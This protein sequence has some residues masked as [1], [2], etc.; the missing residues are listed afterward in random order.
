ML[1]GPVV[2]VVE[3][4]TI[5]ILDAAQRQ[6]KI[7]LAGIDAPESEQPFGEQSKERLAAMIDGKDVTVLWF[8]MDHLGRLIGKVWLNGQDVNLEM[9]RAGLAWHFT[10]YAAEQPEE[11]RPVYA[12]TE[13]EARTGRVGLWSESEPVPPW[14]WRRR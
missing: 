9:V 12:A 8:K 5:Y 6:Y 4:D 1:S 2:K 14:D 3:G 7:R 11:D 10:R 13:A